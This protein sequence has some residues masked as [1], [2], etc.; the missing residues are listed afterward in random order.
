[1]S[2][3]TTVTMECGSVQ[4]KDKTTCSCS[5]IDTRAAKTE[6]YAIT[7]IISVYEYNNNMAKF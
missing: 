4:L 5:Q 6:E 2:A 7:D 3:C 1:M